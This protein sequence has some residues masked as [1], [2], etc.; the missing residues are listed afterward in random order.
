[1]ATAGLQSAPRSCSKQKKGATQSTRLITEQQRDQG[2][3][4]CGAADSVLGKGI[5]LTQHCLLSIYI[6]HRSTGQDLC[7]KA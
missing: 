4:L 6:S 3:R 7:K 2:F 1:M 5:E